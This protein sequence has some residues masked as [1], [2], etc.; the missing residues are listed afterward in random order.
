MSDI[1]TLPESTPPVLIAHQSRDIGQGVFRLLLW[2]ACALFG[3]MLTGLV[4]TLIEGSWD[5]IL[6]FGFRFLWTTVWNPVTG[7]FGA[8]A[9]MYGTFVTSLMALLFAG[10]I[11]VISAIFLAEF[12]PQRLSGLLGVLIEMLAAVPS[13][14]FGLWGLFVLAPLVQNYIG[15]VFQDTLGF[16]PLFQGTIYGVNYFTA[17]LILALMI[18]PTIMA[19]TRDLI[20]STPSSVRE[21]A[22]ALGSTRWEAVTKVVLP[23]LQSGIF[24]AFMLALG[25]ALGETIAT[26]MVIGN[27]PAISASLFAPGYTIAAGIANEFTEATSQIYLSALVELGLMLLILSVAVNAVGRLFLRSI[28]RRTG[29]A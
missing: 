17:A 18:V 19:I 10:T 26:T 20:I 8:A 9:F 6:T 5:S 3:I 14:V 25:R 12:A 15:P 27:R 16:L 4:F 22:L 24:G 7:K 13:V 23:N 29:E 28:K 1:V 21:S 2:A 11:G